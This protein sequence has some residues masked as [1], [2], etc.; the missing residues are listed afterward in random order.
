[1]KTTNV[2]Q[3]EKKKCSKKGSRFQRFGRVDEPKP[4]RI[5]ETPLILGRVVTFK[6]VEPEFLG[7]D[8][9]PIDPIRDLVTASYEQDGD[10]DE[11]P[12]VLPNWKDSLDAGL[13]T[14]EAIRKEYDE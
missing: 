14:I 6:D 10:S 1:M 13:A 12:E 11:N 8:S 5:N 9:E 2:L 3:V 7:D 4:I